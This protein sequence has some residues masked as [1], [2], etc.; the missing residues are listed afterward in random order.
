MRR[1]ALALSVSVLALMV[2][3]SPARSDSG[4]NRQLELAADY[5]AAVKGRSP[6]RAA[7]LAGRAGAYRGTVAWRSGAFTRLHAAGPGR[8]AVESWALGRLQIR[9]GTGISGAGAAPN[10]RFGVAS[11]TSGGLAGGALVVRAPPGRV[12]LALGAEDGAPSQFLAMERG[13]AAVYLATARG[14]PPRLSV[15][16]HHG[17]AHERLV[18]EVTCA[19]RRVL[20]LEAAAG[21]P[22]GVTELQLRLP[23]SPTGDAERPLLGLELRSARGAA[24]AAFGV[25]TEPGAVPSAAA[26]RGRVHRARAWAD[27]SAPLGEG[28]RLR[29][30]SEW[31]TEAD[32]TQ[33]RLRGEWESTLARAAIDWCRGGGVALQVRSVWALAKPLAIEAGG[34]SWSGPVAASGATMDLPEVPAYALTPSLTAAGTAAGVLIDWQQSRFR[35]RLG[36]T[37]R[38][39]KHATPESRFASRV[40]LVWKNERSRS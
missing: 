31:R 8:G 21:V 5:A 24:R 14:A 4:G 23:A 32:R 17:Q 16:A 33:A 29:L 30:R 26:P 20:A 34:A 39:R 6:V 15:L 40:E 19:P 12:L 3:A 35:V 28:M 13:G 36:W 2:R 9:F 37:F 22:G 10:R 18:V 11:G 27:A 38:Q 7:A 25:R 1:V